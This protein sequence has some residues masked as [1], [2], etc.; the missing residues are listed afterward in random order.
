MDFQGSPRFAVRRRIG[1]GGMGVVYE[2]YDRR[3][4]TEVALKTLRDLDGASL[5]R[6]KK[7]FRSLAN[8]NHPNLIA[9]Y[10]LYS[11][12][13]SWFFSMELIRGVSFL[14]WVRPGEIDPSADATILDE[15]ATDLRDSSEATQEERGP[16][17][18]PPLDVERLRRAIGQLALGVHALHE[19]G[20]L[21][22]DLKPTNVMVDHHGR[23]VIL[24]F[25]LVAY[26]PR[27]K[28]FQSTLEHVVGTAGYMSPEQGMGKSIGPPS[29]WYAVGAM[30]F[31]ALVGRRPFVGRPMDVL[32]EKQREEAPR[33]REIDRMVP[34]DLDSLAASLLSR[35]PAARPTGA[36]VLDRLGLPQ[37][38]RELVYADQTE[39]EERLVGRDRE[40]VVLRAAF[41]QAEEKRPA[42][43]VI[44]GASG[45]GKSAL[46]DRFLAELRPLEDAVILSGGCYQREAVPFKAFDD[47]IDGLS[48]FLR[49]LLASDVDAILPEHVTALARVFPVLRQVRSIHDRVVA[50]AMRAGAERDPAEL[51]GRAFNALRRLLASLCRRLPVVLAID[52]LQWSDEDS[53]ELLRELLRG[54]E[55]PPILLVAAYRVEDADTGAVRSALA[56]LKE[57]TAKPRRIELSTLSLEESRELASLLLGGKRPELAE[58]IA[59]ESGGSPYFVSELVLLDQI[60][61]ADQLTLE[62][63]LSARV[64][65]LPEPAQRLLEMVAA[66]GRPLPLAVALDA[67]G[68]GRH[69]EQALSVLLAG[70]L[71]RTRLVEGKEMELAPY[72]DRIR[73][74]V[75]GRMGE[76][77][78]AA[79]HRAL[80]IA[81]ELT[82]DPD[83][84]ALSVHLTRAGEPA[85][86]AEFALQ[87]ARQARATLALER[88]AELYR[89]ALLDLSSPELQHEAADAF[90][91]AG[92][93]VEAAE[94]YLALA[95][96]N[97]S[98][99]GVLMRVAAEQLLRT[100]HVERGVRVLEQVLA[101][102]GMSLAKS[103]V[104]QLT[105][106]ATARLGVRLRGIRFKRR[107]ESTVDPGELERTDALG[108]VATGLG[109][110]DAIAA[111]HFQS[112]HLVAALDAGE[113]RRIVRALAMEACY[114]AAGGASNERRTRRLVETVERLAWE[115]GDDPKT[116][117]LLAL[118]SMAKG[119]AACLNGR[120]A[121]GERASTEAEEIF[122]EHCRG[123][124]WEIATA[125]I[126][127]LMSLAM[128]GRVADL[129]RYVR[130]NVRDALRRGDRYAAA[131]LR[132]GHGNLAW[133]VGGDPEGA[134]AVLDETVA[135]LPQR[136]S[137]P[138]AYELIARGHV[139][140]YRGEGR[141]AFALC[142]SVRSRYER[143]LVS[144]VQFLRIEVASLFGRCALAAGELTVA[145]KQAALLGRETLP[146]AQALGR[147][148]AAGIEE[149]RG[150]TQA[151]RRTYARAARILSDSDLALHAAAAQRRQ[152]LLGG[153]GGAL[154]KAEAW[155]SGQGL[156][157]PVRFAGIFAPASGNH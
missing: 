138:H 19:M 103:P 43:V 32:L 50:D 127:R 21:H 27:D 37:A 29:D 145:S 47:L 56:A 101:R 93:G 124:Q 87:A 51:R 102:F 147:L 38:K 58:R 78:L 90:A 112:K 85:R 1:E 153:P 89:A 105:L 6:F 114:S 122:R 62:R 92:H 68:L 115:L 57:S 157:D 52:D 59:T 83:A 133:L 150:L 118:A 46:I 120:F 136:F 81:L 60:E 113:P 42:I 146:F 17:R 98:E 108:S 20:R 142:E 119:A 109:M 45:T 11:N 149:A 22:R 97:P 128:L 74:A 5:Y 10:D 77:V 134:E 7:E 148:L 55:P 121:E 84:E 49:S 25:G 4:G 99:Q 144:R 132:S 107:T 126:F 12:G 94:L 13:E 14:R 23:A 34:E 67:A 137:M 9:L 40:L 75:L 111:S 72:H 123:V 110:I 131:N 106:L 3:R 104:G 54:P 41:E 36:E 139:F 63:V 35:D 64:A 76:P 18:L 28:E 79:C 116:E 24:D 70:N 154:E 2:A 100:G 66:S 140:L 96:R 152:G 91:E 16:R 156:E 71:V 65:S 88:A 48:R 135:H 130:R 44:A 95:R 33:A 117:H 26:L 39:I 125:G 155:L 53:A 129:N 31:E 30:L 8:I 86:A 143:S 151:A 73:R 141:R 61:S 80:A 82:A 15:A 69:Q